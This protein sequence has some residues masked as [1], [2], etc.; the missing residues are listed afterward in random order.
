MTIHLSIFLRLYKSLFNLLSFLHL[1]IQRAFPAAKPIF[2]FSIFYATTASAFPCPRSLF[3]APQFFM[4][5]W[6]LLFLFCEAYFLFLTILC[7][8]GGHSLHYSLSANPVF[9]SSVFYDYGI[10]FSLSAKPVFCSSVFYATMASPIFKRRRSASAMPPLL[11]RP[12]NRLVRAATVQT[13]PLMS[14]SPTVRTTSHGYN[15]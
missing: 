14:S 12:V 3:S 1:W 11:F 5:L 7:D 15:S 10:C 13:N 9:C 2:C 8:Y 6:C 4:R